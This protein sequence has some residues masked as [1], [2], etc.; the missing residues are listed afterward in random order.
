MSIT[1]I[2]AASAGI[3]SLMHVPVSVSVEVGRKRVTIGEL[4][5]TQPGSVFK[6]ERKVEEPLDILVNNSLVAR[7]VV[8]MQEDKFGIQVTEVLTE[9]Q[10]PQETAAAVPADS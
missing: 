9:W 3:K 2:H 1:D 8:V 7:G 6:L 4:L 10:E 5:E